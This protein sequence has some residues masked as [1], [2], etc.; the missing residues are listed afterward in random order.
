MDYLYSWLLG[1][2]KEEGEVNNVSV[3]STDSMAS[4]RRSPHPM[5]PSLHEHFDRNLTT[6]IASC[7]VDFSN[8]EERCAFKSYLSRVLQA[9]GKADKTTPQGRRLVLHVFDILVAHRDVVCQ[10]PRLLDTVLKTSDSYV[11]PSDKKNF[12][13]LRL[14][15]KLLR[16]TALNGYQKKSATSAN[17]GC[18]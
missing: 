18:D 5:V 12:V 15:Q 8:R 17:I 14:H 1:A 6:K 2:P 13:D 7:T 16:E 4:S 10:N 9:A 11:Y 3:E